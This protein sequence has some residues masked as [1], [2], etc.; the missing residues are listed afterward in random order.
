MRVAQLWDGI[1]AAAAAAAAVSGGDGCMQGGSLK[2]DLKDA[3]ECAYGPEAR[4][5]LTV[6]N[7]GGGGGGGG[8][9]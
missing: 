4:I 1:V 9:G 7:G 2:P 6:C 5:N 8:G 3:L